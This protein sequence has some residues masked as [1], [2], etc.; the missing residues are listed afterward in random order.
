MIEY[1]KIFSSSS[2]LYRFIIDPMDLSDKHELTSTP[3]EPSDSFSDSLES[4]CISSAPIISFWIMS[5]WF[6]VS[7]FV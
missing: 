7:T 5:F 4:I 6:K 2:E 1:A 3:S